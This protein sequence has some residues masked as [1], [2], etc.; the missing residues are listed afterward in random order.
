MTAILTFLLLL[1]NENPPPGTVRVKH[2]YVDRTE[3]MNI[4]WLEFIHYKRRELDSKSLNKLFPDKSNIFFSD[5]GYYKKRVDP[6]HRYKPVVA[7]SY[8]Q[9][10]EFCAW[11]SKMVSQRMKRKITYRLPSPSE[12]H[13]IAEHVLQTEKEQNEKDLSEII[14]RKKSDSFLFI[15]REVTK[16]DTRVFDLFTNASEMTSEKGI[17]FGANNFQLPDNLHDN[18]SRPINYDSI[19]NSLGFRCI[20]EVE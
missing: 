8:E 19:S 15:D 11:R 12:W 16:N 5:H 20:A 3:I 18:I 10:M 2:Y 7:V 6:A 4:H 9:V 17:A 13:E 14:E 1:M